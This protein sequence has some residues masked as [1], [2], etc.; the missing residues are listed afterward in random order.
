MASM[1]PFFWLFTI[2]SACWAWICS[3][4]RRDCT[5]DPYSEGSYGATWDDQA[6]KEKSTCELIKS[7]DI[8][9]ED[10]SRRK[11]YFCAITNVHWCYYRTLYI[12]PL[13]H[14]PY[15]LSLHVES[16]ASDAEGTR[17]KLSMSSRRWFC[18]CQIQQ[19]D[20]CQSSLTQVY[21]ERLPVFTVN[22][23]R[24]RMLMISAL[25]TST[26]LVWQYGSVHGVQLTAYRA[27]FC[28]LG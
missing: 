23:A 21:F 2:V 26:C 4:C 20:I 9:E 15:L 1:C 12:L 16:M 19:R 7:C 25:S 18:H 14:Y 5:D 8:T 13:V 28:R 22:A 17:D 3:L 11:N 6:V 27:S 24:H 10:C